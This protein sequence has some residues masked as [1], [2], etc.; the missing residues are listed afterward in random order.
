MFNHNLPP[1]I[2]D[3]RRRVDRATRNPTRNPPFT[4]FTLFS[5]WLLALWLFPTM[6]AELSC[7]VDGIYVS[8]DSVTGQ[9][10]IPAIEVLNSQ[11]QSE[12]LATAVLQQVP[13]TREGAWFEL[14]SAAQVEGPAADAPARY[15]SATGHV[16]VNGYIL[17]NRGEVRSFH[18]AKLVLD[19][20]TSRFQIEELTEKP[21]NRSGLNAPNYAGDETVFSLLRGGADQFLL[22]VEV[23]NQALNLLV[24]IGSDALLVFEDRLSDCNR[25]VRKREDNPIRITDT[26][27]SKSYASGTREGLL[28][29]APVRIGAYAHAQ[30]Q[31]MLIQTPD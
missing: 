1:S 16:E 12:G 2:K 24:D 8:Y 7:P 21:F 5:V 31:I 9:L 25:S 30:M 10:Q 11:G 3:N 20:E 23:G 28:A 19:P 27:V 4:L 26:P 29:T 18:Q 22:P 17:G 6:A 13:D 15:E 14:V